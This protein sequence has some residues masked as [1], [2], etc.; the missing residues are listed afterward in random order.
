MVLL[1]GLT[2]YVQVGSHLHRREGSDSISALVISDSRVYVAG[3]TSAKDFP[4]HEKAYSRQLNASGFSSYSDG[5]V[6]QFNMDQAKADMRPPISA[7]SRVRT[8]S[9]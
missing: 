3:S 7:V 5:F 8:F 4:T 6:A 1:L 9:G 2:G